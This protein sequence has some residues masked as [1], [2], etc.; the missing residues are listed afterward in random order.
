[1][2]SPIIYLNVLSG[3]NRL[4]VFLL[5]VKDFLPLGAIAKILADPTGITAKMIAISA[6]NYRRT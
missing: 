3:R 2:N 1:M 5:M 6:I 4:S